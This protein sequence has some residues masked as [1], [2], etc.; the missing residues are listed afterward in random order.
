MSL[1]LPLLPFQWIIYDAYTNYEQVKELQEENE[2]LKGRKEAEATTS[3]NIRR[4]VGERRGDPNEDVNRKLLKAA[5]I[6]ERMVNQNTFN[7]I[8][9]GEFYLRSAGLGAV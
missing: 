9:L 4:L 7:D 5:R 3:F 2:R 1:C 6:L 8:A